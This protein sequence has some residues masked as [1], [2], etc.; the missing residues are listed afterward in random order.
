[1][2]LRQYTASALAAAGALLVVASGCGTKCPTETPQVQQIGNCTAK[3][4]DTVSVPVRLCPT[5]NQTGATCAVDTSQVGSSGIIQ[6]DP[7]VE[8]CDSVSS[9]GTPSPTCQTNPLTCT[10]TVP[11]N[12]PNGT[13][14]LS[15]FDPAT[16]QEVSGTLTV[17]ANVSSSCPNI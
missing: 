6:L 3:P 2:N 14:K 9:C 13:I 11:A 1:M 8:A 15:A 5:C 16:S 7:T 10:F 12:T 17:S 4:G